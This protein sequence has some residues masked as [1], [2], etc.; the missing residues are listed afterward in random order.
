MNESD[1]RWTKNSDGTPM[2]SNERDRANEQH[3]IELVEDEWGCEVHRFSRLSPLDFWFEKHG[4]IVCVAELKARSNSSDHYKTVFLSLRKW[5]SLSLTS[6]CLGVP[7]VFIAKFTDDVRWIDIRG[8]GTKMHICR[9]KDGLGTVEPVVE[10]LIADMAPV[11]T[12]LPQ[13]VS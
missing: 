7:A 13:F 4:R 11:T 10:V 12:G 2:L 5:M 1:R 6:T 3:V 9:R 8:V